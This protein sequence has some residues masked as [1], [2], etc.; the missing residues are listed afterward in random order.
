MKQ[1]HIDIAEG[2]A[3]W[4]TPVILATR[5]TEMERIIV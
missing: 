5:E 1:S 2:K 4:F 3:Q